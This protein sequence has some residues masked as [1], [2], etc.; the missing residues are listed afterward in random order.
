MRVSVKVSDLCKAPEPN[1]NTSPT[2]YKSI[3]YV[4]FLKQQP[5]LLRNEAN[6]RTSCTASNGYLRLAQK[7]RSVPIDPDG[8]IPKFTAEINRFTAGTKTVLVL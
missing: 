2:S 6:S 1:T 4:V 7:A 8:N 5:L 3:N